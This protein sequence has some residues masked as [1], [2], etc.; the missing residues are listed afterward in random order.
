MWIY[1]IKAKKTEDGFYKIPKNCVNA[2]FYRFEEMLKTDDRKLIKSAIIDWF[3][4][5]NKGVD[6]SVNFN[7]YDCIYL[8]AS[9][10]MEEIYFFN[11]SVVDDYLVHHKNESEWRSIRK[12]V[13]RHKK[14]NKILNN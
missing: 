4:T 1:K 2:E 5:I 7:G 10:D 9:G 11:Y 3:N 12:M 13:D 14:I 8:Q 6:F